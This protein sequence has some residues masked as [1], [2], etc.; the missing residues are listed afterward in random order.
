MG[1]GG[2]NLTYQKKYVL[3]DLGYKVQSKIYELRNVK[4]NNFDHILI[5]IIP[6][7]II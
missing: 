7:I 5:L 4:P 6:L 1:G 3:I 2:G